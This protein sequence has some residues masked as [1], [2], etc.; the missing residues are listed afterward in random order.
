MARS[1]ICEKTLASLQLLQ[2]VCSE[3][4]HDTIPL[5]YPEGMLFPRIFWSSVEND[6]VGALLSVIYTN[7]T[8]SILLGGN[9]PLGDRLRASTQDST[10]L[11]SHDRFYI[12]FAFDVQMNAALYKN[13][14]GRSW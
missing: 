10:L 9:A 1:G 7:I 6:I 8:D 12:Q 5:I 11:T 13:D 3:T 4:P 2:N 14:H